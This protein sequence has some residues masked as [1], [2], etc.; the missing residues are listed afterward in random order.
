MC[1]TNIHHLNFIQLITLAQAPYLNN[2]NEIT[3]AKDSYYKDTIFKDLTIE[4]MEFLTK[5]N[6]NIVLL[7]TDIKFP[8]SDKK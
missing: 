3:I 7:R 1:F 4:K 8:N 2:G 5:E 6:G